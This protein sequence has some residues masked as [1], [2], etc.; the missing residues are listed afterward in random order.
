MH[1]TWGVKHTH[2]DNRAYSIGVALVIAVSKFT[3][4]NTNKLTQFWKAVTKLMCAKR[5]KLWQV[6][7]VVVYDDEQ[8]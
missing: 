6:S 5:N 1:H 7:I 4:A 3:C 8:I 2:Y